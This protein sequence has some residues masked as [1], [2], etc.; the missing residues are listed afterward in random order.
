MV[1]LVDYG[2]GNLRSLANA[3]DYMS[4][5]WGLVR[6]SHEV[7]G[8]EKLVLPGVGS[9]GAAM[10]KLNQTGLGDAIKAASEFG[11]PILG[12]CLG[13]QLL[14]QGSEESPKI[15]GL[16]LVGGVTVG[17]PL[18]PKSTNT[19]FRTVAAS[20][21]PTSLVEDSLERDYYFNH[22]YFV[23]PVDPNVTVGVSSHG[24]LEICVALRS[25]NV[26][27]VQFHPEKSQGQG[28]AVLRE[29]AISGDIK[30]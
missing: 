6:D 15:Q 13:M 23:R 5:D 19:G 27:G 1:G 4:I 9:F 11:R 22:G 21:S 24:S 12:I 7:G 10:G 30:I 20:G 17:L 18:F 3:L 26:G 25:A 28:L 29:F 16:G 2:V 14:T 8:Y